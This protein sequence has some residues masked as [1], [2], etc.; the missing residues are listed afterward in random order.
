MEC[1]PNYICVILLTW[2]VITDMNLVTIDDTAGYF[3]SVGL[4][5]SVAPSVEEIL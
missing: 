3:G 4:R 5:D 2:V 1:D